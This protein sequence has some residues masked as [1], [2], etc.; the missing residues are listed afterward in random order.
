MKRMS[1]IPLSPS[2]K[3][4]TEKLFGQRKAEREHDSDTKCS[5]VNISLIH[6]SAVRIA[7]LILYK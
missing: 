3:M 7:S 4:V 2:E 5:L 1:Q 6:V